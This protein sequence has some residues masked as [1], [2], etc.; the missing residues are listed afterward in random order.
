MRY[1]LP[2]L[3]LL[4]CS[5]CKYSFRGISIPPGVKTFFVNFIEN[6]AEDVVATLSQDFTSTLRQRVR[7]ESPLLEVETDPDVEFKGFITT[8]RVS[9]EAPSADV[10]VAFNRITMTVAIEY[11]NNLD[12]EEEPKK[13]SFSVQREFDANTNLLDIQ[14]ALIVEMNDQLADLIFQWAFTNW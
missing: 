9:S 6:N 8:Y 13:K 14:D 1:I 2:L 5:T 3:L 12:I 10:E 4:S 11:I 7:E